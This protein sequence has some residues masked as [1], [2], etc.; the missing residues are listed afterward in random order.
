MTPGATLALGHVSTASLFGEGEVEAV[1]NRGITID[2]QVDDVDAEY[3]RLH[4]DGDTWTLAP[5]L[6]PW[7]NRSAMLR[8]P[9]GNLNLYTPFTPEA[10]A[11]FAGR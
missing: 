1:P 7:G 6:M 2:W 10:K 11:R 3:A 5:T 4:P 8:D 9:D